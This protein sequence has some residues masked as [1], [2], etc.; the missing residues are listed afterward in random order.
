MAAHVINEPETVAGIAP[1]IT[2][3][4]KGK[5]DGLKKYHGAKTEQ[6]FHAWANTWRSKAFENWDITAE[7]T[8]CHQPGLFI[9]GASD[10]YGTRKQLNLIHSHYQGKA[11][12]I[13]IEECGHHPHLEKSDSVIE[14]IEQWWSSLG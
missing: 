4:Q 1:A 5:L 14:S 7:I 2:A 12:S 8:G 11:Q 3:F 6:L 9:Q 10:Q 13:W